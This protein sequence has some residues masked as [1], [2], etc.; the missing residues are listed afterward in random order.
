M[1]E[2]REAVRIH[3]LRPDARVKA[4]NGFGVVVEDVGAGFDD[5]L[6][7][8]EVALEVGVSTSIVV[9]RAAPADRANRARKDPR[10]AILQVVPVD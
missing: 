6:H 4:R 1:P 3:G 8:L 2:E 5:G 9:S 10:A 7:R